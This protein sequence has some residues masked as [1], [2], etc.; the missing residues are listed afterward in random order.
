M[1]F[2]IAVICYIQEAIEERKKF[3]YFKL[4]DEWINIMQ[5]S[6]GFI[7]GNTMRRRFVLLLAVTFVGSAYFHV[8]LL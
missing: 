7:Q 5:Q 4:F 3:A 2:Q 6:I 1:S 8:L